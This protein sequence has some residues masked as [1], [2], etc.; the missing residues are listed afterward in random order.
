MLYL[1]FFLFFFL[2]SKA[3]LLL[4]TMNVEFY[5]N[6]YK[7]T[8][9]SF[10]SQNSGHSIFSYNNI[11]DSESSLEDIVI[12]DSKGT[13]GKSFKYI[14]VKNWEGGSVMNFFKKGC[15]DPWISVYS[16]IDIVSEEWIFI[17]VIRNSDVIGRPND[18]IKNI[19]VSFHYEMDDSLTFIEKIVISKPLPLFR[20]GP[21]PYRHDL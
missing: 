10:L 14:T 19:S 3:I 15:L 18:A 20:I 13:G 4:S 7:A 17:P 6:N 16:P 5:E 21:S 11:D 1:Y 2:Q 8:K 9:P 12:W